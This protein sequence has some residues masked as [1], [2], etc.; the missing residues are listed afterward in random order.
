MKE[1]VS[2][3]DGVIKVDHVMHIVL[4]AVDQTKVHGR[5]ITEVVEEILKSGEVRCACNAGVFNRPY[6]KDCVT[7]LQGISNNMKICQMGNHVWVGKAV[8]RQA[9]KQLQRG[10]LQDRYHC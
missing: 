1:N 6:A 3:L 8:T 7:V 4:D 9:L 10:K 2:K 5:N